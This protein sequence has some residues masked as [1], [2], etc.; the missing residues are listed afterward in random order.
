GPF[1][2]AADPDIL[3]CRSLTDAPDP[4]DWKDD[5]AALERWQALRR[6]AHASAVG[7]ALPRILLRRPYGRRSDAV[8]GF[9]FEEQIASSPH[10]T[11]LWGNPALVCA[12]FLAAS[13]REQGWEMSLAEHLQID[14]L[15]LVTFERDGERRLQPVAEVLLGEPAMQAIL[16]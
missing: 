2:A 9:E 14:D 4:R 5:P 15:P 6:C 12:G 11:Y 10:A 16:D 3:G 7:L 8:E 1:L 13:F